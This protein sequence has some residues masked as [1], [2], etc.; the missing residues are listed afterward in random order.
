MLITYVIWNYFYEQFGLKSYRCSSRDDTCP[1]PPSCK[2]NP[3]WI[4][5]NDMF[6]RMKCLEDFRGHIREALRVTHPGHVTHPELRPRPLHQTLRLASKRL[7]GVM[8]VRWV[9]TRPS[10]GFFH[11]L[12]R[13]IRK[14]N[15]IRIAF[16]LFRAFRSIQGFFPAVLQVCLYIS[17]LSLLSFHLTREAFPS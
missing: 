13:C 7:F 17:S 14:A 6:K 16:Y 2:T 10:L 4:G 5:L 9:R 11:L 12:E 8:I 3:V 1:T 15:P